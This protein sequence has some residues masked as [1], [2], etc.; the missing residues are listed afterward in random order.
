MI[1][2]SVY[3]SLKSLNKYEIDIPT[4]LEIYLKE[5]YKINSERNRLILDQMAN[6][7]NVFESNNI[8]YVFLKGSALIALDV[9]NMRNER[10]LGDIDILIKPCDKTS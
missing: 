5:I 9:N 8:D 2:P 1:L 3:F 6:I 7:S 4:D 10:M